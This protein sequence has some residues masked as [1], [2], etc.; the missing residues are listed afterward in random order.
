VGRYQDAIDAAQATETIQ[1]GR[2]N[3]LFYRC[4]SNLALKRYDE[5]RRLAATLEASDGG[6]LI[7]GCR[8]RLD[9]LDG[10][11]AE[12]R[13]LADKAA[14]LALKEGTPP[15]FVAD[16]YLFAGDYH[17]AVV[18]LAREQAR[19]DPLVYA[20]SYDRHVPRAF[21]QSADWLAFTRRPRFVAWRA[22][23]EKYA[24]E[25]ARGSAATLQPR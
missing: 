13:Q 25:I 15:L 10:K 23:R 12:A 17:N 2:A 5:A 16:A 20:F 4:V 1:P 11:V 21:L 14:A 8:I 19:P 9:I 3:E 24:S 22:A 7:V 18:W 6:R